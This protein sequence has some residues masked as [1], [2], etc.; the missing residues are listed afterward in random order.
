MDS[1]KS[2]IYAGMD[3]GFRSEKGRNLKQTNKKRDGHRQRM[4]LVC[5]CEE[6]EREIGRQQAS[7][8]CPHCGGKVQAVDVETHWRFCFLPVCFSFKRKYYCS[9]CSKRL[10]LYQ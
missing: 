5:G 2:E 10:V 4:C 3:S 9:L 1:Y 6:E 8:A 7:G